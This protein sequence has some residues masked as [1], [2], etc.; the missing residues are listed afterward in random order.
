ML[1]FLQGKIKFRCP[2][3]FLSPFISESVSVLKE[4]AS[5][6]FSSNEGTAGAILLDK[7]QKIDS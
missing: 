5:M 1:I 3:L 4:F 2:F 6:E 7:T